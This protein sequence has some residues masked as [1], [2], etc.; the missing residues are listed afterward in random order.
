M[1]LRGESDPPT[2][3]KS[4]H[5]VHG[6]EPNVAQC[7]SGT[8][9]LSHGVPQPSLLMDGSA[10]FAS[11]P[12]ARELRPE[13]LLDSRWVYLNHG[14]F[15]ACPTPVFRAYQRF[16][17]TLERQPVDFLVRKFAGMLSRAEA[18]LAE[19]VGV[20]D[21]SRLAFAP[22][23]TTALNAVA[24]YVPLRRGD[25]IL[26]TDLEYGSIVNMWREVAHRKR[27]RV[28]IAPISLPV[29][30]KRHLTE[31]VL[32]CASERTRVLFMSHIA[33]DSAVRFPVDELCA[34]AQRRG[35]V[36]VVDGAHTPGQL[37]LNVGR[38]GASCYVG[39]CHKW[40]CAPKGSAF[41]VATND[42]Q[43]WLGAPVV[44]WGWKWTGDDA[45]RCRHAWQGTRDP[46][47]YL[48]VPAAI[49]YLM[50]RQ[51]PRVRDRCRRLAED[52]L[53][54]VVDRFGEEPLTP[55]GPGWHSQMLALP[56]PPCDTTRL[57]EALRRDYR[58][59]IPVRSIG[60][61]AVARISVQG[62]TTQSDCDMLVEA[63]DSLL[64]GPHAPRR[65]L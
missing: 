1:L 45:F 48:A 51:W 21:D 60:D 59:E 3:S 17:R 25:E 11:V 20:P 50:A 31:A 9:E 63:L 32:S 23:T 43:A 26:M 2:Q 58:I 62:Y 57:Q 18:S 42:A 52:T 8:P 53:D 22:N 10:A 6:S 47:A 61:L 37:P 14:A 54:A 30:S 41:V 56:L 64:A 33:S 65:T 46:A 35:I 29:A 16:Q 15:G 4:L 24:S 39:S 49:D 38:V 55:S 28:V 19:H 40:M 12:S 27:A 7:A 44:S 36:S 13:F 34:V 5:L